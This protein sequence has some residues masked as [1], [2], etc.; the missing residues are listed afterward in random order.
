MASLCLVLVIITS[1]LFE[2]LPSYT[3][4]SILSWILSSPLFSIADICI[5]FSS[6]IYSLTLSI[7]SL[8]SRSILL[9]RTRVFLGLM[10][11]KISR[12]SSSNSL[13]ESSTT[14]TRSDDFI[15]SLDFST[16]IF[17]TISSVSLIP[18]VSTIFRGIPLI[19]TNSSITSLVVPAISVT[20]ALFSPSIQFIRDDFPTFGLPRMAVFRPSLRILPVS[21]VS[22][23]F[24]T[25]FCI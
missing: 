2:T 23:I 14:N 11:S 19:F 7:S 22:Y 9:I 13:E 25:S 6:A 1:P 12:S 10:A 8:D 3:M 16:P 5:I 20:M 4:V 24:T 21:E 17:S 15:W 18:A